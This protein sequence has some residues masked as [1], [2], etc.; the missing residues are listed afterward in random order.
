MVFADRMNEIDTSAIRSL[1]E[2]ASRMKNP[3]NLAAGQPD[4]NVPE[5]VKQVAAQSVLHNNNKYVGAPGIPLLKS[6]IAAYLDREQVPFGDVLVSAGASGALILALLVLADRNTDVFICDPYF[7]SYVPMIQLA[8]AH[9]QYLDT[10]PDFKLTPQKLRESFEAAKNN[11]RRKLFIYN[12]PANPTGVAYTCDE[13]KA[14]AEVTRQYG[15]QVLSDEVYEHF[16]FDFAHT[17]WL[18]FDDTAVLVRTFGKSWGM[19]GWRIG[20]AAGPKNVIGRMTDLHQLMY[21][22]VPAAFQE[23]AAVALKTPMVE[24][25]QKFITRRDYVYE[26]LKNDFE[27]LKSNGTFYSFVKIPEVH[28][29]FIAQCLAKELL[30]VP[31][32]AFSTKDTHF[33][34][35]YAVDDEVLKKGLDMLVQIARGKL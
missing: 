17:S 30:I 32:S 24:V 35:S 20:Y 33:R 26:T 4:F 16:C 10:Y 23:A 6:E 28:K 12:S 2:M 9:V 18:R 22:C 3:V 21:V 8:G 11:G 14:L 1:F 13:V 5:N 27:V 19:P 7:I 25:M 29:D 31:G 15:V 34:L